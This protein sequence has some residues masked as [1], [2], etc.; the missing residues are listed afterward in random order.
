MKTQKQLPA[1]DSRYKLLVDLY[2]VGKIKTL[3][4]A[5]KIV[6]K[7]VV[8]NDMGVK[9]N[10]FNDF[11]NDLKG[12]TLKHFV[13]LA[14]KTGLDYLMLWKLFW[15]ESE[16]RLKK[17]Y[18]YPAIDGKKRKLLVVRTNITPEMESYRVEIDGRYAVLHNDRLAIRAA[19]KG[20][21]T[22]RI[23]LGSPWF[24]EAWES[25]VF[26]AIHKGDPML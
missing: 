9:L 12:F 18:I 26:E 23:A 24:P 20:N 21:A 11:W 14:D 15:A 17:F 6:P 2:K 3:G 25:P 1:I 13:R 22:W 7:T 4:D 19:G 16:S 5:L 8:A 10:R